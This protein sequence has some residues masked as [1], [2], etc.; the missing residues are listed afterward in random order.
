MCRQPFRR[1]SL[2]VAAVLAFATSLEL[3]AAGIYEPVELRRREPKDVIDTAHEFHAMFERRSLLYGQQDVGA[4]VARI[5]R[6][7]APPPTDDY[8]DYQFFVIRDPSPNAFALPN[9]HVYVHTGMLAR[10]EDS[11]QLAG[12]L[13]HEINHVAGHHGLIQY[14]ITAKKVLIDIVGG[15]LASL[16]GQLR[17]SRELEQEA[18]DRAPPLL[19]STSYDPHAV[20]ELFDMLAEDFE[21]LR[22]R[23][24]TIWT[25]HPDPEDRAAISRAA[26]A[27]LPR[28][29]RDRSDY[30]AIM[31]PLRAMTVRDY[32]QADYPYT[33]IALAQRLLERYPNDP[34]FRLLLGDAWRTLG[35]RS[36]FAPEDLSNREKWRKIHRR[37]RRTREERAEIL[38]ETSEGR[39]A[40]ETNLGYA[41]NEYQKIIDRDAN[42]APAYRGIGEVNQALEQQRE[43]ARFYLEYL[44]RAPDASDRSVIISRLSAIRDQ[45][46]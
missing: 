42:Y 24:P 30:D 35:P 10:L 31:Y 6:K 21:G 46:Q 16:F 28:R 25:T 5:G 20:P 34:E 12:L 11:S 3:P 13:A 22:P 7:I 45:I 27:D 1:L 29:E 8:I 40:F 18:D 17:H 15:S 4:M 41:R 44:R 32:I 2:G 19:A 26:V 43:A 23:I 36:E 14:R 37:M 9:G 33:A 38:L 39:R